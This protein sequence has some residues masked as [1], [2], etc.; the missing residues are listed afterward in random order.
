MISVRK[1]KNRSGEKVLKKDKLD[2]M[3]EPDMSHRRALKFEPT[4]P[5]ISIYV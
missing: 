5:M 4:Q 3:L 1:C 2:R